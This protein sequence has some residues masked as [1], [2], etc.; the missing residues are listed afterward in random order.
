MI[1]VYST[2]TLRSQDHTGHRVIRNRSSANALRLRQAAVTI[3]FVDRA[4]LE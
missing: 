1:E 2:V 3:R 4:V